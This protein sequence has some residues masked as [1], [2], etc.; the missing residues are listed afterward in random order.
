[1]RN[2]KQHSDGLI[3]AYDAFFGSGYPPAQDKI[4]R[5]ERA[6]EAYLNAGE[7]AVSAAPAAEPTLAMQNAGWREVEKQGLRQEDIEVAPIFKAMAAVSPFAKSP[8]GQELSAEVAEMAERV[9]VKFVPFVDMA[10]EAVPP[11]MTY[12]KEHDHI[13]HLLQLADKLDGAGYFL[14]KSSILEIIELRKLASPSS[15]K[16]A[17]EHH[18]RDC[19]L[20]DMLSHAREIMRS[21]ISM[22]SSEATQAV[23]EKLHVACQILSE[24]GK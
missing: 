17:D 24:D 21:R 3:A 2:N 11:P 13:P 15:P 6:I 4:D 19:R 5:L 9:G 16:D 23:F 10:A 7:A 8:E 1:M 20:Y 22:D 12:P 14:L 18:A